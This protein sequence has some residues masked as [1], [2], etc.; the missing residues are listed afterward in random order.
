MRGRKLIVLALLLVAPSAQAADWSGFYAGLQVGYGW[1]S[2]YVPYTSPISA[3]QT[4]IEGGRYPQITSNPAGPMGGLYA[5][6]NYQFARQWFAGLEA[7]VSA[8]A[9]TDTQVVTNSIPISSNVQMS[10]QWFATARARLGF[11]PSDAIAVYTT[12][13]L[14]MAGA[15]TAVHIV[16]PP[17]IE[18][19]A[20]AGFC[21][22]AGETKA[23][24]TIGA[25]TEWK[26]NR[27]WSVKAEYLYYDVGSIET[28]VKAVNGVTFFNA[29]ANLRG[30]IVRAGLGYH[31]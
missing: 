11:L 25:G 12:G 6:Y 28:K 2:S 1:Q 30:S 8:S 20:V 22:F 16:S 13:G 19:D 9:M 29:T 27:M 10:L 15:K 3:V 31:F 17:Q 5:G 4:F 14:A 24:W 7:D 18:C 26:L 23:G 21:G